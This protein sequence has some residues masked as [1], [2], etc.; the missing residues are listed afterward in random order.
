MVRISVSSYSNDW[1]SILS[2]I[3]ELSLNGNVLINMKN[4]I[5]KSPFYA[6]LILTIIIAYACAIT[7]DYTYE[8]VRGVG[9]VILSDYEIFIAALWHFLSK[10]SGFVFIAIAS[11]N[12]YGLINKNHKLNKYLIELSCVFNVLQCYILCTVFKSLVMKQ[13]ISFDW[14]LWSNDPNN[15]STSLNIV[16]S[17]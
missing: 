5:T 2:Y 12:I 10:S 17:K 3:M 8:T 15:S 14:P 11:I 6:G 4:A 13:S 9:C 7:A 1:F 16:M